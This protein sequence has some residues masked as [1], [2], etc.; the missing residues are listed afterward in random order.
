M[1][2]SKNDRE[3]ISEAIRLA[4]GHTSGEIVP[5]ILSQSD[6]YPAAHFRLAIILSVSFSLITYYAYDFLDPF[7]LIW[8]QIPGLILGYL[9]GF[10]PSVKALFTTKN[11]ME[12]EVHQKAIEVFYHNKVSKTKDRTGIMIFVSLLEHRVEV[13]GDIGINAVVPANF[14]EDLVKDLTQSIGKGHITEGIIAAIE[15]CGNSLK[16]S[17]PIQKDNT[18]EVPNNLITDLGE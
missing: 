8:M 10:I 4:E 1:K 18:N 15:T 13:I 14:W 7:I 5:V 3:K 16:G 2:I 12:E 6:F 17:F 11:E 9:L